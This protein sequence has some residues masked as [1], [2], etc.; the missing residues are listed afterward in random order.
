MTSVDSARGPASQ[1]GFTITELMVASVVMMTV[2]G[3]VLTLTHG[4]QDAF[5]A[6][7][8]VSDLQQR[9]RIGVD[10]LTRDLL[11]AGAGAYTGAWDDPMPDSVAPVMP[12]RV[13]VRDSDPMAGIFYRPDVISILYVPGPGPEVATHT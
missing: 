4:A 3:T 13:G 5:H 11:M 1:A 9:L 10:T 7:A 2:G 12:Y 6:Q 8:E